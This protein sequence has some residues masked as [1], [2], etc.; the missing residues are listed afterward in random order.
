MGAG[1]QQLVGEP[2]LSG[3][4]AVDPREPVLQIAAQRVRLQ[5]RGE[6]A[7]PPQQGLERPRILR[8]V[9]FALYEGD[10]RLP[11]PDSWLVLD[12]GRAAESL[13][14]RIAGGRDESD[15]GLAR[16]ERWW[17]RRR[18]YFL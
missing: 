11:R 5:A 18:L 13:R 1:R 4:A 10:L 9:G 3:V 8:A 16:P 17:G 6:L 14:V 2:A 12:L 15:F 7:C